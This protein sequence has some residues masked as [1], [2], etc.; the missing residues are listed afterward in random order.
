ML[1]CSGPQPKEA[2]SVEVDTVPPPEAACMARNSCSSTASRA[3]YGGLAAAAALAEHA[4][5]HTGQLHHILSPSPTV[6]A[7][8]PATQHICI[9]NSSYSRVVHGLTCCSASGGQR[10]ALPFKGHAST[11]RRSCGRWN[12]TCRL[13]AHITAIQKHSSARNMRRCAIKHYAKLG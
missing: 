2:V 10:S 12:S 5:V 3:A 9:Y 6:T 13:H 1:S 4:W 11:A 7:A 8:C